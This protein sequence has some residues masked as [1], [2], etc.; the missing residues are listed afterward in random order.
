[1]EKSL[2]K[3]E[4]KYADQLNKSEEEKDEENDGFY[5]KSNGKSGFQPWLDSSGP[6][7]GIGKGNIRGVS[8]PGANACNTGG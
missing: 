7:G 1:M 8:R 6:T 2:K 4:E 5:K 3:K